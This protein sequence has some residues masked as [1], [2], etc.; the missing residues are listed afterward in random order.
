MWGNLVENLGLKE[1]FSEFKEQL[2]KAHPHA[3]YWLSVTSPQ[4]VIVCI[5]IV[6]IHNSLSV[7]ATAAAA[8]AATTTTTTTTTTSTSTFLLLGV[9]AICL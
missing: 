2:N 1:G 6:I 4:A 7:T 8:A 5:S 3:A 9:I